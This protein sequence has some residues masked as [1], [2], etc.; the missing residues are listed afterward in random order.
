MQDA[1]DDHI[2]DGSDPVD[3][4]IVDCVNDVAEQPDDEGAERSSEGD[5]KAIGSDQPEGNTPGSDAQSFYPK[6]KSS[7]DDEKKSSPPTE[8]LAGRAVVEQLNESEI[9]HKPAE[10]RDSHR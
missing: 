8:D 3:P 1:L 5:Q 10:K 2:P 4:N 7:N 6:K 9:S